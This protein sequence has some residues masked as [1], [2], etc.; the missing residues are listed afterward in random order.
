MRVLRGISACGSAL[1]PSPDTAATSPECSQSGCWRSKGLDDQAFGQHLPVGQLIAVQPLMLLAE[2]PGQLTG[3]RQRHFQR[4]VGA[5]VQ[6]C[7]RSADVQVGFGQTLQL[8]L[9]HQLGAQLSILP[10]EHLIGT[11]PGQVQLQGLALEGAAPGHADTQGAEHTGH[12]VGQDARDV[13]ALGHPAGVLSGGPAQAQQGGVRGVVA[14]LH[15]DGGD[16]PGHVVAGH[17]EEVLG[18]VRHRLAQC[19]QCLEGSLRV[20][21]LV[22]VGAEQAREECRQQ[23][24]GAEVGVGHSGR[25]AVAVAGWP[26]YRSGAGRPHHQPPQ[27]AAQHRPAAGGD[28]VYIHGRR[29]DAATADLALSPPLDLA[30]KV[31]DIGGGAAH[32]EADHRLQVV[33]AGHFDAADDAAGRAG[34]H[35]VAA[36]E[37]VGFGQVAAGLHES[38]GHL[39][40]GQCP[41]QRPELAVDHRRQGGVHQRGVAAPD[42]ANLRH[43]LVADRYLLHAGPKCQ[44]LQ[45]PLVGGVAPG[46]QQADG[47]GPLAIAGQ[48]FEGCS[49]PLQVRLAQYF[50]V[51]TDALVD[52]Q[53]PAVQ[54][55]LL[56]NVQGEQI[57][58]LLVADAQQV[59]KARRGHQHHALGAA[60]QQC[61]G[62][63]SG[64]DVQRGD[65]VAGAALG[66]EQPPHPAFDRTG[67]AAQRCR[68]HFGGV[69]P[70]IRRAPHQ[71]GEGAPLV[72]PE[73]PLPVLHPA[74]H[75]GLRL[76]LF[77]PARAGGL[78]LR[79]DRYS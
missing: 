70:S 34:Q 44:L 65:V 6:Q 25:A 11:G 17:R 53:H 60:L 47:H 66:L 72:G 54:R 39:C 7:H 49:C 76:R 15:R 24:P 79:Q 51:G 45:L 5:G 71:I 35:A 64:A 61:V 31:P 59:G 1:W 57:G 28:A 4:L 20:G 18:D 38:H 19:R 10:G 9:C 73:L 41:A 55:R 8:Q 69:Q 68:Q 58:P 43:Q 78:G 75:V 42:H 33:V 62:A 63:Q 14:A 16:C 22:A 32:V 3:R 67:L 52:L 74:S 56:A 77:C 2:L 40:V 50:A 46:V 36:A 30:G 37:P 13:Q 23:P 27:M 26:R 48:L 29:Q 21:R 12:G